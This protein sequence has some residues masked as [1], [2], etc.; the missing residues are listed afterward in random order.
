MKKSYK[1]N[2]LFLKGLVLFALSVSCTQENTTF[3]PNSVY[4]NYENGRATLYRA[5]APY[6]IKGGSGRDHIEKI[7]ENGGNSVRTWSLHE[8]EELLDKAHEHDMTVTLGIEIGRPYWG[9]DFN[10][11]NWFA[12]SRKIEELR[13]IIR[14]YKDHPALLMWGVGNEVELQGGN[15]Y[16]VYLMT[17]RV[18][19][20]IKEEDPNHPT[21]MATSVK[22]IG[23]SGILLSNIDIMGYNSFGKTPLFFEENKNYVPRGWK[24]AYLFSEIGPP[25]HW[26]INET[27]WGAPIE[28]DISEKLAFLQKYWDFIDSD[29]VSLLGSYSFYW[30]YKHEITATWFSHF[31]K[32]GA[33]AET[34]KFL[35]TKWR[36][37]N[38]TNFP[39]RLS[40]IKINQQFPDINTYLVAD[41]LFQA[42]IEAFDPESD[43]VTYRWELWQEE[44]NF[45]EMNSYNYN[46]EHLLFDQDSS[47]LTFRTPKNEGAYRL[48]IYAFDNQGNFVSRNLPFYAINR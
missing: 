7:G 48:Y 33:E 45:H 5:G 43:S 24:K 19:K 44:I 42:H 2:L 37:E 1:S 30:G 14:K 4:V 25:G 15:K 3:N 36:G 10:Y 26:E 6:Y 41:S 23:R 21:M 18:A 12:V 40:P 31:S 38:P 46:M 16:L 27:E 20:M 39:P 9:E 17:N 13:P 29:T 22:L 32:E 8:A 28:M 47:T 34:V 35:K 11:W